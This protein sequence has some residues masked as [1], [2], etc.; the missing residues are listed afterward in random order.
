MEIGS[1]LSAGEFEKELRQLKED[2]LAHNPLRREYEEAVCALS[3]LR[4]ELLQ[5]EADV[6]QIARI[7]HG[8][9]REL[10]KIYKDAAPPLFREY[11][12][13]A[14]KRKYGDPLGPDYETLRKKKTARQI[15]DSSTRPIEDLS[16]RLTIDGF[17]R[18]YEEIY[19]TEK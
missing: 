2:G 7:L 17:I 1:R 18:W 5:S 16:N 11:I 4:E 14:T 10:G 6:E 12:F 19:H 9:R 3:S 8:K 13:Y 15:I